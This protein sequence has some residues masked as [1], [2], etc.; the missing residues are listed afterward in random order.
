MFNIK[1]IL[2]LFLITIINYLAIQ[3]LASNP[4]WYGFHDIFV[5][6]LTAFLV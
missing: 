1:L 4:L 3:S 5:I 6:E 2:I